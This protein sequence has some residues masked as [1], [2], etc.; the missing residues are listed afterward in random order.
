MLIRDPVR[1]SLYQHA[2]AFM[3]GLVALVYFEA[4]LGVD[5]KS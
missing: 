5:V 3:Q 2:P 4:D 1:V